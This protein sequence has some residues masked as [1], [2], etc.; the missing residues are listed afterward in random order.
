MPR[1]NFVPPL[2]LFLLLLLLLLSLLLFF[3]RRDAHIALLPASPHLQATVP[4][5]SVPS[6]ARLWLPV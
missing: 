6:T 5:S 1:A 4:A 3:A 2:L